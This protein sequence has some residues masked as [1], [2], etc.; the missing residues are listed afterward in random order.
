MKL[1]QE[2]LF[3]KKKIIMQNK[4]KKCLEYKKIVRF[5]RGPNLV[6][7]ELKLSL[8]DLN[9]AKDIYKRSNYKWAIVHAY[10]S[11]FHAGRGLLYIKRY[12]EKSHYC[13][14]EA[15][16]ELYVKEK[17]LSFIF[18]ENIYKA[19]VLREEADYYGEY[20]K[21]MAK[22]LIKKSEEFLN[23]VKRIIKDK[24]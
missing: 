23:E 18:V 2:L 21:S 8:D 20:K 19:K 10:Y 3:G 14:I 12:R 16:R 5:N 4:F 13:L 9:S 7:K 24:K 6:S 1:I 17:E 22:E 15:I 11:M